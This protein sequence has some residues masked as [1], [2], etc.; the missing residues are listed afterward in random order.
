MFLGSNTSFAD[1]LREQQT[2]TY[3]SG[4]NLVKDQEL[5]F[6]AS[7]I[8]SLKEVITEFEKQEELAKSQ[9][10]VCLFFLLLLLFISEK[11]ILILFLVLVTQGTD[12]KTG[13]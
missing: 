11:L 6:L 1:L 9:N 8:D 4:L 10:T 2:P 5:S 13:G 3:D 7:Q 12:P